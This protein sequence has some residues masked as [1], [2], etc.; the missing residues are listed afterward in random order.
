[1]DFNTLRSIDNS[2]LA[3]PA[4]LPI[5][6]RKKWFELFERYVCDHDFQARY[7]SLEKANKQ[8]LL[9]VSSNKSHLH[10]LTKFY[11]PF[12][13]LLSNVELNQQDY[14]QFVQTF[15]SDFQQYHTVNF[16]PLFEAEAQKWQKALKSIGFRTFVFEHSTNWYDE[17]IEN[18]ET[19]WA[20]R[21]SRLLNTIKRK[22]KKLTLENGYALFIA[23]PN[24]EKELN[25]F[26]AD[27]HQV[28][29][30]SWKQQE[31]YIDFIDELARYA[32]R[33][34]ELRLG[35]AYH[36]EKPVASQIWFVNGETAYIFKLAYS[37]EY[38]KTSVGTV[39]QA[40]LTEYVIDQ[41]K[42]TTIDFL[43]GDDNY[44]QHWMMNSR[45]LVGIQAC[46]M[47]SIQGVMTYV[48]NLLAHFRKSLTS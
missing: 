37:E 15:K 20:R 36:H 25:Q 23:S 35:M 39:L 31:P 2:E 43:T 6:I 42:V 4:L 10:S 19:Y 41:D 18:I 7:L 27:Y 24:S 8:L 29:N 45:P 44:K 33:Q 16:V 46:N 22:K 30:L 40:L 1:M 34:G 14:H 11:N 12:F 48:K 32:W 5:F 21:P 28:Y 9:P 13:Q 38:S 26:L 47:R 3:Q 17:D